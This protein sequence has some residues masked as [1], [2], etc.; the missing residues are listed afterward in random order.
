MTSRRE[1]GERGRENKEKEAVSW[2]VSDGPI[3]SY[4]LP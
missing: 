1:M 3:I 2:S 4:G